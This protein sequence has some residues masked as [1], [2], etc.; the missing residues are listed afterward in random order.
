[1]EIDNGSNKIHEISFSNVCGQYIDQKKKPLRKLIAFLGPFIVDKNSKNTEFNIIDQVRFKKYNIPENDLKEFFNLLETVRR[2]KIRNIGFCERQ[3]GCTGIMIDYDVFQKINQRIL[4]DDDYY[5]II[6]TV[7]NLLSGYLV[8]FKIKNSFALVIRKIKVEEKKDNIYKDG[9]HILFPG[10]KINKTTK[11]KLLSDLSAK[12]LFS[13]HDH[14]NDFID[15]KKMVDR[16]SAHV[17]VLFVGNAKKDKTS[18]VISHLFK[19]SYRAVC[20][21]DGQDISFINNPDFNVSQEFSLNFERKDG[22]IQKKEFKSIIAEQEEYEEEEIDNSHTL[23]INSITDPDFKELVM[24]VGIL[25]VE[26]CENY[27]DWFP[28]VCAL[29]KEGANYKT[30]AYNFSNTR[31]KG[32]RAEFESTFSKYINKKDYPPYNRQMI[33]NFARQDNP[34]EYKKIYENGYTQFILDNVFDEINQGKFQHYI[35]ATLLKKM[36]GNK[37]VTDLPPGGKTVD[38]YEFISNPKVKNKAELWKWKKCCSGLNPVNLSHYLS[39]AVPLVLIKVI[40]EL[41]K[42]LDEVSDDNKDQINYFKML[43]KNIRYTTTNCQNNSFKSSVF[44]QCHDV[45]YSSGFASRLDSNENCIGVGNGIL[46][47]KPTIHLIQNYNNL[48]ISKFTE[49]NYKHFDIDDNDTQFAFKT[50]WELFPEDEKDV[51]HYLMFYFAL[52]LN[53]R[54]KPAKFVF[55]IGPGSNGKSFLIKCIDNLFSS[56]V[57]SEIENS[58]HSATIPI[59]Y[60]SEKDQC[61]GQ[62]TPQL[63]C[64]VNARF[65][66]FTESQK[67][68]VLRASKLKGLTSHEKINV[69]KLHCNQQTFTHKSTFIAC[70]NHAFIVRGTDDGIWRRI[71]FYKM[72][73]KFTRTPNPEFKH[74]KKANEDLVL[75][76]AYDP[77]FL[78]SI[79]SILTVYSFILD[80]QYNG[81]FTEVPC[82]TIEKETIEY[83]ESQDLI[84]RFINKR[85]VKSKDNDILISDLINSYMEWYIATIAN[86]NYFNKADIILAFENSTLQK[87]MTDGKRKD[88]TLKGHRIIEIGEDIE[89]GEKYMKDDNNIIIPPSKSFMDETCYKKAMKK[90]FE[91]YNKFE[92]SILEKME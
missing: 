87:Y 32:V 92:K 13:D 76:T 51:F 48:N 53:G 25:S 30:T 5:L 86:C 18:Y 79:M 9:F 47:L 90:L 36:I 23:C 1:M 89:S 72:K 8:D 11:Y 21:I 43:I 75:V 33:L 20:R 66:H 17:P 26:R 80:N 77:K 45:F 83:R 70:S 71:L 15:R 81:K 88:K 7:L 38:W 2:N 16:N 63:A 54:V 40:A 78:S 22:F 14:V 44:K 85:I 64:L 10:I 46:C 29:A 84:T 39:K 56:S 91:K 73:Y 82:N 27:N 68:E 67:S 12:D 50:L 57:K 28:I 49:T 19:I 59:T 61:S 41:K 62:A 65:T 24:M 42:R 6:Q 69:R 52:S 55:L 60:L 4:C 74:H 31:K 35:V 58:G 37:F 34:I 3:K